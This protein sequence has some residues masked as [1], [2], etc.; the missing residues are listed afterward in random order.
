MESRN[1]ASSIALKPSQ[2][3][4]SQQTYSRKALQDASL[5]VNVPHPSKNNVIPRNNENENPESNDNMEEVYQLIP[6]EE[7][8]NDEIEI[9]SPISEKELKPD[10][11]GDEN[12]P[13]DAYDFDLEVYNTMK[14]EE[15]DEI[16]DPNLFKLQ[17]T[18]TPKIRNIVI[19]W[20]VDVL[21]KLE[22]HTDTLY[23]TVNIIDRFLSKVDLDKCKFQM[24]ACAAVL[25]AGK[26]LEL[27]PPSLRDLVKLADRSFTTTQLSEAEA[28]IMNA[29]DFK[30][31]PFMPS[32]F[33]KRY[34][35]I[36]KPDFQLSMISHYILETTLLDPKFIGERPS[37]VA[38][39]T[40]CLAATIYRGEGQWT[41]VNEANTGY[42][43]SDLA[44]T[45]QSL[46]DCVN[47]TVASRYTAIRRKY[48]G[49]EMNNVSRIRYPESIRL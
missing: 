17:T 25:I 18:I 4:H 14:N 10:R 42:S 45:V 36:M 30:I 6:D 35:R 9:E 20:I 39:A 49:K 2:W 26:N 11:L 33:M 16:A 22:F 23:L 13:Q 28:H 32:M 41:K 31:N 1:S 15:M 46:L 43:V 34:L 29:L 19:D 47:T 40:V 12:D 27:I 5:R 48:S 3:N 8:S 44:D 38:A 24:Y 7:M 21:G 37:K